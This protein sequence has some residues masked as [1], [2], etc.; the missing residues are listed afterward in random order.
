MARAQG[1]TAFGPV[2]E[3]DELARLLPQ[4]I[5]AVRNGATVVIDAVVQTGYS[6]AMT[7]GLTRSDD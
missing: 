2:L 4:A 1:L 6:P 3:V 7:A 5:E